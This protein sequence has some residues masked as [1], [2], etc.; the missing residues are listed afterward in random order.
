MGKIETQI[1]ELKDLIK[2][3]SLLTKEALTLNE[4]ASYLDVSKPTL[5][6]LTSENKI[7]FYKPTGKIYF[8]RA[9]L[10]TWMLSNKHSSNLE[11]QENISDHLTSRNSRS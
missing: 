7:T 6:K 1:Q 10:D 3:Q 11:L 5:Y 9:E 8:K 4:A 2:Q